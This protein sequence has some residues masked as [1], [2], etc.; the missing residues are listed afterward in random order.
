MKQSLKGFLCP[1]ETKLIIGDPH[2]MILFLQTTCMCAGIDP[3]IEDTQEL[4]SVLDEQVKVRFSPELEALAVDGD[5]LTPAS[6]KSEEIF[7]SISPIKDIT[8][9]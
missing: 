6:R 4:L 8:V 7:I 9:H 2:E 3:Y 1:D 5:T